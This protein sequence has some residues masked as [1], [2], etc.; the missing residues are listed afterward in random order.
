M[1]SPPTIQLRP[2]FVGQPKFSLALGFSQTLPERHGQFCPI[3]WRELEELGKGTGW[4]GLIV[5]RALGDGNGVHS[6]MSI[7][8]KPGGDTRTQASV[9]SAV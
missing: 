1:F 8:R 3:A 6:A 7:V 2:L 4:H 5:S 9:G